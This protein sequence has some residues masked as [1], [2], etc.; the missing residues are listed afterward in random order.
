[1]VP[2][3]YDPSSLEAVDSSDDATIIR[4]CDVSSQCGDHVRGQLDAVALLKPQVRR[5]IESALPFGRT[6]KYGHD[7]EEIGDIEDFREF[8]YQKHFD[9]RISAELLAGMNLVIDLYIL[10]KTR[11][12]GRSGKADDTIP[13]F[14][15]STGRMQEL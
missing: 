11:N 14:D 10:Q 8:A 5:P 15:D 7:R 12:E 4:S 6:Q 9:Q 13:R 1:M 3:V 2:I